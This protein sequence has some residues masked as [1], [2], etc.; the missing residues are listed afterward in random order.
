MGIRAEVF[1][2]GD[3]PVTF[4]AGTPKQNWQLLERI[5]SEPLLRALIAKN[6]N[7]VFDVPDHLNQKFL[8]L[9]RVQDAHQDEQ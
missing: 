4:K 8:E 2:L 6:R 3:Q 1:A 7:G 9:R 5:R